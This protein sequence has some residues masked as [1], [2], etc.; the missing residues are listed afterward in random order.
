MVW[1]AYLLW[2]RTDC[3]DLSAAFAYH[4]LQSFFPALLIG[5]SM[6]S[7]WLGRDR[8]LL[9]RLLHLIGQI[10][11]I[12]SQP[13][14]E[15]TLTRVLRQGMGAGLLGFLLLAF[16]ANNIYL[17]LQRGADRLWWNRPQ[18]FEALTAR[19]VVV[20]FITLRLKAF[21][22]LLFVGPLIVLDQWISNIR[23]IGF[24]FVRS[25]IDPLLPPFLRAGVSVSFGLDI[26]ISLA[27][28]ILVTLPCSGGSPRAAF[29]WLP[30]FRRRFS[31]DPA[32]RFSISCWDEAC[33]PSVSAFRP[34]GL[35]AAFFSSPCG[36]GFWVR[37]SITATALPLSVVAARRGGDPHP[38]P[39]P[40]CQLPGEDG[41]S[42][43]LQPAVLPSAPQTRPLRAGVFAVCTVVG[44][45]VIT[46][47]VSLALV[48]L[49]VGVGALLV[50]LALALILGWAGIE[51]LAAL[52]RWLEND[53]RFQ[54]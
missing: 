39:P 5:L 28:A 18:D 45:L 8:D 44:A 37:S 6:A 2:L 48:P 34:M 40:D 17:S 41:K 43:H 50:W 47:A 25:W 1:H 15:E 29:P 30:L 7:R 10:I 22:L 54:R 14:V 33:R 16:S 19:Q 32:S 46:L 21:L 20:R 12:S 36:S 26:S 52:E 49:V 23:F 38:G 3:I 31:P 24:S 53:P 51:L 9:D 42:A 13:V 11:P 4:T 27:I 35:W